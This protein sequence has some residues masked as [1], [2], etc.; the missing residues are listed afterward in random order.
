MGKSVSQAGHSSL[1]LF[2]GNEGGL[3]VSCCP[4]RMY[5]VKQ[6][7]CIQSV[8]EGYPEV[9]W[10]GPSPGELIL[11]ELGPGSGLGSLCLVDVFIVQKGLGLSRV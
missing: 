3:G 8:R 6:R 10:G 7:V 5:P 2:S 11:K 9:A 4:I 1:L